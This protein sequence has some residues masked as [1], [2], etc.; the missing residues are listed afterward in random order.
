MSKLEIIV[1]D[2]LFITSNTNIIDTKIWITYNNKYFPF[3]NWTDFTFPILEEWK[4]N[5]INIKDIKNTSTNLFFRKRYIIY[6]SA[7]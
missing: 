6:R 3:I 4:N 2:D 5:L 7:F 1:E